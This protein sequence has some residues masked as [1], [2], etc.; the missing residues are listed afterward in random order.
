MIARKYNRITIEDRMDIQAGINENITLYDI[1][2]KI[3]KNPS[4]VIREIKNNS[5]IKEERKTCSHCAKKCKPE[6]RSFLNGDCINFESIPC[7]K[8]DKLPYVCN[9][10]EKRYTCKSFKRYYNFKTADEFSRKKLIEPRKGRQ[11]NSKQIKL[12]DE[13]I[14]PRIKK[15]QGLHHIYVTSKPLQMICSE[16]TIRRCLYDGMFEAKAHEL[17]RF[18]RYKRSYKRKSAPKQSAIIKYGHNFNDFIEFVEKNSNKQIFEYDSVIGK[19]NDHF[20][21]LTITHKETNFQFGFLVKKGLSAEVLEKINLLKSLFGDKYYEIFEINLAD[22][23][24]EFDQFINA[25]NDENGLKRCNVFYARPYKSSDK[26]EC[27]RN[28]EFIRMIIP[29][30]ETLDDSKINQENINKIFSH[31][32]SYVRKVLDNKTP[33]QCFVKI[34]G[35]DVVK[36]LDIDCIAPEEVVLKPFLIK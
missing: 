28:H 32:N 33:Y 24:T 7:K 9:G 27:E 1:A 23:G 19:L 2:K 14:S 4:S 30:G 20:A 6:E 25:E 21:I 11:L 26:A 18:V 10:C 13:I 5:Q 36:K 16:I 15:G 22:N 34:F 8:R 17:P 12:I 31:I 35:L 3:H 29:K